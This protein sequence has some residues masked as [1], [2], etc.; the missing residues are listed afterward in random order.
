MRWQLP[1]PPSLSFSPFSLAEM[2]SP[3][4]EKGLPT[5]IE[6]QKESGL[7][8]TSETESPYQFELLQ[9]TE[10]QSKSAFFWMSLPQ[11]N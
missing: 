6:A 4:A 8:K 5:G 9:A 2:L 10:I 1:E 3:D 11:P 7:L